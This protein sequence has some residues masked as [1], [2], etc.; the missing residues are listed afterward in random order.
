MTSRRVL[1][2]LLTLSV[3]SLPIMSC[4]ATRSAETSRAIVGEVCRVWKPRTYSSRDTQES[5]LEIRRN[6]V[7]RDAFCS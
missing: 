4:Q 2:G 6:N 3:A 5:Q 1:I 7:S